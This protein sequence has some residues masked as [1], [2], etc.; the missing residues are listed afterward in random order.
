MYIYKKKNFAHQFLLNFFFLFLREGGGLA[1]KFLKISQ[2]KKVL[3]KLL[4]EEKEK[5]GGEEKHKRI[6]KL[7]RVFN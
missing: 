3:K 5:K 4:E 2:I 6:N 7:F 1:R